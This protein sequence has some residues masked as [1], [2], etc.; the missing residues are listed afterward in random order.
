M[1]LLQWGVSKFRISREIETTLDQAI[2]AMKNDAAQPKQPRPDP[3]LVKAQI[4]QQVKMAE[5]ASRERIAQ[6][7]I[8]SSEEIAALKAATELQK[9]EMGA[10]FDQMAMQMEAIMQMLGGQMMPAAQPQPQMPAMPQGQAP[11]QPM[12]QPD[13]RALAQLM[14]PQAPQFGGAPF[15]A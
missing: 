2:A 10:R 3:A 15:N 13:P 9:I 5:I 7:E 1:K 14:Q 6:Q 8:D 11:Q 12:P 4:D